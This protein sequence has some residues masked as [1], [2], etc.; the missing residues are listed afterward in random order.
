MS[1]SEGIERGEIDF[2]LYYIDPSFF[3]C[4]VPGIQF[5][6]RVSIK[7]LGILSSENIYLKCKP[8]VIKRVASEVESDTDT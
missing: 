6:L 7:L 2:N 5:N 1:W 4:W 3:T 8:Q